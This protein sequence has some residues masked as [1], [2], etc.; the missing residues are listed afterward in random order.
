MSERGRGMSEIDFE[1]LARRNRHGEGICK[2][3]VKLTE[4]RKAHEGFMCN[5]HAKLL[6]ALDMTQQDAMKDICLGFELLTRGMGVKVGSYGPRVDK[7]YGAQNRMMELE[8]LYVQWSKL[9][10]VEKLSHAMAMD[11]I[12]YGKSMRQI[13]HDRRQ[14]T[15]TARANLIEAL[16]L[17]C[18]MRGWKR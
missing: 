11:A 4:D 17:Y 16:D 13:D 2:R 15:G 7:S 14:K 10:M 12:A 1:I 8:G 9:C 5:I 3:M 6:D 18:K